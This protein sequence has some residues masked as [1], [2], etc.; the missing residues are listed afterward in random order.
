MVGRASHKHKSS[1]KHKKVLKTRLYEVNRYKDA[2]RGGLLINV[3]QTFL[4]I[5]DHQ[6]GELFQTAW[7]FL[8]QQQSA[9]A[10]RSFTFLCHLHPFVADFW[11]GL[12]RS[13]VEN[14]CSEEA[15]SAFLMAE[16]IDP[17]RFEFYQAAIE[18]CLALGERKNAVMIFHR[19][20]ARRKSIENYDKQNAEI[21]LLHEQLFHKK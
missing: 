10:T 3:P 12:G 6:L 7:G 16:T 11:Y 20:Q 1:M 14:N 9:Q 8:E 2:V 5:S 4:G 13:L 21:A 17:S 19:L 15:L 18:C